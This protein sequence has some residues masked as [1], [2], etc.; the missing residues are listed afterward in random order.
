MPRLISLV[1]SEIQFLL[2]QHFGFV[3][4]LG[5]VHSFSLVCNPP[6]TGHFLASVTDYELRMQES[7]VILLS[8]IFR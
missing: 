4:F 8:N 2:L 5:I 7:D 1:V 6:V 3:L